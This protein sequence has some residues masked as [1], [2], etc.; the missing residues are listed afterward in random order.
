M[1]APQSIKNILANTD[2]VNRILD[3]KRYV[4]QEYQDYGLR[5]SHRL[6]DKRHKALYIRLAKDVPRAYLEKAT[7]FALDY[8]NSD[9]KG[10][11]FMWKLKE[12]C[13]EA[14]V[15]ISFK[16]KRKAVKQRKQSDQI[17]LI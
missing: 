4:S 17:S 14:N 10:R 6:N 2:F 12:I 16:P 15:K 1:S 13:K 7:S 8:P 3:K 5:L 11:I 9:N